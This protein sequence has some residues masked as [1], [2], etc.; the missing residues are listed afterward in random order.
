MPFIG[1]DLTAILDSEKCWLIAAFPAQ[2]HLLL[3]RRLLRLRLRCQRGSL[4]LSL[5]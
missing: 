3:I 2:L 1:L 5:L 4:L